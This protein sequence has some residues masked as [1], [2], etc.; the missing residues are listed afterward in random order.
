MTH[1]EIINSKICTLDTIK[2]KLNVWRFKDQ[3]IVFT[4]GCFDILHQGHIDYLSKASDLG[5]VLIVGLNSDSSTRNLKGPNRPINDEYSRALII[6]SLHFVDAVVLFDE[7]T[8]YN[9]INFIQ[10]DVLVKGADY[11]VEQIAGS[12]I[13]LAKGG[14]VI[15]I[16][17]LPGFSTSAIEARIKGNNT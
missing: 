8:P 9:L 3:K 1:L 12:D 7:P 6:A 17:L 14:K 4:N 10:P 15:T 16:E 11:T 5:N 13:V 2:H